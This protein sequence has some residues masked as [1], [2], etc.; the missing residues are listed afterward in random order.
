MLHCTNSK[1]RQDGGA[2][3]GDMVF[4][5]TVTLKMSLD[6]WMMIQKMQDFMRNVGDFKSAFELLKTPADPSETM[7]SPPILVSR[8]SVEF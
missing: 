7:T 1:P 2:T 5:L 3:S 4:V 6:L 8:P